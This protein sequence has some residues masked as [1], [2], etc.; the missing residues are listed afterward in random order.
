MRVPASLPFIY[1]LAIRENVW[2][3][4]LS[5]EIRRAMAARERRIALAPGQPLWERGDHADGLYRVVQGCIRMSGLLLEGSECILDFYGPDVWFGDV[6]AID[7]LS[8]IY[9]MHAYRATR[10]STTFRA[11]AWRNFRHGTRS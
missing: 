6:G 5:S 7:G 11:R 1:R 8:R 9:D 2:L 4:R 10:R 3:G